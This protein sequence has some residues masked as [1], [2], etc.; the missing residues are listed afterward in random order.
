MA[1]TP[2]CSTR[3]DILSSS[4]G[5][6]THSIPGSKPRW[7]ANC[8]PSRSCLSQCPRQESNLQTFGFKPNRSAVGVPGRVVPDGLEPS[9]PGGACLCRRRRDREVDS[10][11]FAPRFSACGA[12]VLLLDDEPVEAEAVRLE[13]T[14]GASAATCFRDRLLIRPDHFR[15]ISKVPGVGIEPGT[16]ELAP[17]S[18]PGVTTSSN[19]PGML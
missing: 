6:R 19:Y 14:S 12:G 11:G 16:T 18:E 15:S 3:T 17:G 10:L 5:T 7:S 4:G 8:L 1:S 9:L 13:P 2:G